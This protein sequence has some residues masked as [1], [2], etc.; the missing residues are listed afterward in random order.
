[1]KKKNSSKLLA[2]NVYIIATKKNKIFTFECV[3]V[4]HYHYLFIMRK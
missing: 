4:Y 3:Y 1:M 2:A